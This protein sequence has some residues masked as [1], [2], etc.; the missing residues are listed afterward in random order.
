MTLINFQVLRSNVLLADFKLHCFPLRKGL[1]LG[2]HWNFLQYSKKPYTKIC[3]L[4][5]TITPCDYCKTYY[6]RNTKKAK[7]G[8]SVICVS[9][10]PIPFNW[11]S[12]PVIILH[13]LSIFKPLRHFK[14]NIQEYP[15]RMLLYLHKCME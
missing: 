5:Y 1:G 4:T 15:N 12:C 3:Q 11:C 8:A 10:Q 2:T 6:D 14:H 7:A 9:S 13:P